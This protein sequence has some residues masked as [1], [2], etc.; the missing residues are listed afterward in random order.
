MLGKPVPKR[1]AGMWYRDLCA[2][3]ELVSDTPSAQLEKMEQ[4]QTDR[5]GITRRFEGSSS[6]GESLR[7]F[8]KSLCRSKSPS[9]STGLID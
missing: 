4:R 7:N 6:N 5:E 8:I 1:T 9:A 3:V 2:S